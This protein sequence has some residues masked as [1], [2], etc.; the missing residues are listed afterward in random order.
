MALLY[1]L[2]CLMRKGEW[3]T[4]KESLKN[5]NLSKMAFGAISG[6][7]MLTKLCKD[8]L[9][10]DREEYLIRAKS[11]LLNDHKWTAERVEALFKRLQ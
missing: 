11:S 9:G 8:N 2:D 3:E 5:Q 7:M 4:L 10:A 6:T 1:E